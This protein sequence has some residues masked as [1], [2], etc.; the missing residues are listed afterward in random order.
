MLITRIELENIKSY[1]Q[2]SVDVRRGTTAISGSNGA[3]K[4]TLVEAI[5]FALFDHLSYNQ[6]QFIREGE[7]S[8]KIVIHLIGSDERPYTVER[9]IGSGAHW[10]IYDKEADMRLEQR[11]DVLDKLHELFGIERGRS[12][13]ALFRDA[14]GVP[15]GTFTSIFLETPAKRK[16]TFDALLQIEDYPTAAK[17]L[18]DT[19]NY[20]KAQAQEQQSIIDRL[21]YETRDLDAWRADL[22]VK[23]QE[24]L[25][26]MQRN[27][28]LSEQL[29]QYERRKVVL[30]QQ[31]EQLREL[32]IQHQQASQ[33]YDYALQ[34]LQQRTQSYEAAR[35]ARQIVS[36][37][38]VDYE[39]NQQATL[40]LRDLRQQISQRDALRQQHSSIESTRL[41]LEERIK[42]HQDQLQEVESAR[43][44]IADLAPLV[45]RQMSLEQQRDEARQ[46]KQRYDDITIRIEQAQAQYKRLK[47]ECERCQ[48]RIS[49]IE[50]LQ[51]LAQLLEARTETYTDLRALAGRR[52][53]KQ[54][55]LQEKI[56]LLQERQKEHDPLNVKLARAE[57]NLEYIAKHRSE[58]GE[59]PELEQRLLE[60]TAQRNR[61]EGNVEGYARSRAQS[62]GGQCPL[63]NES[64]LNIRQRG[65]VSL[66]SYFEDLLV[67]EK[68][69]IAIIITRQ[70]RLTERMDQIQ[71]FVEALS[72]QQLYTEKRDALAE[73]M[74]RLKR[75]ITRSEQEIAILNQ[76]LQAIEQ[77]EQQL[78]EAEKELRES[79]NAD[80]Q[81]RELDGLQKQQE[82]W[83][84]QLEQVAADIQTFQQEATQ[85]QGSLSRLKQ[86]EAELVALNDP[87]SESRARQ[88]VIAKEA[89]YQQQLA[90]SRLQQQQ[91]EE[92]L[93]ALDS[94]LV[95]YATLDSMIA[96]QEAI[97]Q[98]SKAGYQRYLQYQNEAQ[99]LPERT[100]AYQQ[101]STATAQAAQQ[102]QQLQ[103][104]FQQA[105]AAFQQQELDTLRTTIGQ[106]KDTQNELAGNMKSLQ[107]QIAKLEQDI[108]RAEA[109]YHELE[110]ARTEQQTLNDLTKM[111]EQFRGMIKE[112][113]PHVLKAMLADI[114]AE[115]N[116][117]FG[118]VIGDR[119]VQLSWRNDYEI[120]MRRQSVD[121]S[122]AQLSGGEQ[123]SAALAVR[124]A[125]LKKLSTLN[126]A[127]FDEPTQNMDELR[128]MNLAEQIRRVR[129]F[130]QLIV[131]SHDDTFE[132]G[133]DSLVRL[134]KVNGETRILD[135]DDG[136][137]PQATFNQT[138]QSDTG[139]HGQDRSL[140]S[141]N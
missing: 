80:K 105:Q 96:Q 98:L 59:Q 102:L 90:S 126:I 29:I 113:A 14:L 56:R 9:R 51:P 139:T 38:Q 63:L 10:L 89:Q 106:L 125:L 53:E 25:Q 99:L 34:L 100:E 43:R 107:E 78:Q 93:Q 140:L 2:I 87:R 47:Q 4:T 13:D 136:A 127:F 137:L 40:T 76:D 97:S 116:R 83:H 128:R 35:T 131:I 88:E 31:A 94:Q 81:V 60:L 111:T 57:N 86:L 119:S 28:Q 72:R 103:Q 77:V 104:A 101:Q 123:M 120:I 135:D 64:C 115:A 22:K 117:I 138:W 49:A 42:H 7:K 114:S 5:G 129:G 6:S 1:R 15:Q 124:L 44:R 92:Q 70:N 19:Q 50:P 121:R 74:Q 62:A 122:F 30:D 84:R 32:D 11:A 68:Q 82:Q 33:H 75:D 66:E 12:L 130:D 55:Q 110:T 118:E 134:N 95:A 23:R 24:D 48:V 133:L 58:A 27:A 91:S 71:P 79:R 45:E 8:G 85:L 67:T 39:R 46:Q 17:N 3:G 41:Q 20:Y 108:E 141:T 65:I 36:E 52:S 73:Q 16:L 112:A 109:L 37:S 26:N 69:N 21:Q 54:Q 18:L 61:L 132:Q